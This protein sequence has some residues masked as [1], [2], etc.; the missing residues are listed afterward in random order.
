[1][2]A[3]VAIAVVAIIVLVGLLYFVPF[4]LSPYALVC[5]ELGVIEAMKKS[6][7]T[8]KK[9]FSRVFLLILLFVLLILIALGVG[10]VIGFIFGVLTAVMPAGVGRIIMSAVTSCINGY[11][12]VVMT[13]SFMVFYLGLAKE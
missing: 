2:T 7:V 6:L 13:A 12:G 3:I 9:P 4:T 8:A 5:N 11:L 10:L 1:L